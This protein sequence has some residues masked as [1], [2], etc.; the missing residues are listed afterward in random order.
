MRGLAMLLILVGH[1]IGSFG[2]R[3]FIPFLDNRFFTPL[4]G[5]GCAIF[6]FV[7]GYGLNESYKR[8]GQNHYWSKRLLTLLI[9]YVL[10]ILFFYLVSPLS[11]LMNEVTIESLQES[12][13]YWNYYWFIQYIFI[14]YI[15]FYVIKK[16]ASNYTTLLTIVISIFLFFFIR[17]EYM[18]EQSF[19]FAL[20]V[21]VSQNRDTL[22]KKCNMKTIWIVS[23]ASLLV[24]I[25][26]LGIKQIPIIRGAEGYRFVYLLCQLFIKLPLGLFLMIV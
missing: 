26:A 8:G 6:L 24:G 20:G 7:S 12:K 13:W 4:G 23:L 2:D 5:V 10:C 16:I 17:S 19:S 14:W 15:L 9:P 1:I 25:A 3:P 18:A 21:I 11:P 22:L